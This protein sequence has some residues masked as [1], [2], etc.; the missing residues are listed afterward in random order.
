M[1]LNASQ[2]TKLGYKF[3]YSPQEKA[4]FVYR[5]GTT[6]ASGL[7]RLRGE[8]RD[9][10]EAQGLPVESVPD[11]SKYSSLPGF[12]YSKGDVN[13]LSDVEAITSDFVKQLEVAAQRTTSDQS[14]VGIGNQ[15]FTKQQ[16]ADI[17][18]KDVSFSQSA[19][20]EQYK[21][22][23]EAAIVKDASKP[24]IESTQK[25]STAQEPVIPFKDG[26][27]ETQK[28][29][30]INLVKSGR[31]FNE[32]DA[33]NYAY[34]IGDSNWQQYVGTTNTTP[35]TDTSTFTDKQKQ[36]LDTAYG[37][38][39]S[40]TASEIDNKNIDYAKSKGWTP[41][42]STSSTTPP[43]S[44]PTTAPTAP[45]STTTAEVPPADQKWVNDLYQK[46]FD[47]S[48][49]SSELAN[50]AKETPA[51]LDQFLAKEQ[52]TYGYVSKSMGAD[53][54][55]R[56]DDAMAIIEA[57]DLPPEMKALWKNVVGI[58]PDATDF[59]PD[60]IINTFNKIKNETIDPYYKELSNVAINDLKTS[61]TQIQSERQNEL[62]AERA[63]AGQAIRQAKGGLEKAGMTFSGQGI[64]ALG[65]QSA[66]AQPGAENVA[67]PT[68]T[69]FAGLDN[70]FYEGNVN[71]GNR[72]ISTSS[73]A[74]YAAQQQAL[75]A[76][77]EKFLGT[78]GVM[79]AVPGLQYAPSGV[80]VSGTN[81][82]A[83]QGKMAGTLQGIIDN[84]TSSQKLKTN[85]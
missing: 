36:E 56:Y 13:K 38:Q 24:V 3:L 82:I 41:T 14:K 31:T 60:E 58:Y 16:V 2:L 83:R 64:E 37:R 15:D 5:D 68:Q 67:T 85:I 63:N 12:G 48:A 45:G 75:G 22:G 77:A 43:S 1:A 74:R 6:N 61:L 49:T 66:Y 35:T 4:V 40:G 50:W 10:L 54:K 46:Y 79:Q 26:L 23:Q 20:D 78:Q 81:E 70:T 33:K 84:W 71:Q 19:L 17:L 59:K 52:K 8:T 47:R 11:M 62:E 51:A 25:Q 30:I 39:Q 55:K 44:S 7:E 28:Q 73:A 72:L 32:I 57:S 34:A 65:A 42:G 18:G 53:Q 21:A 29:S 80:N 69:P 9:S 76:Q 27:S